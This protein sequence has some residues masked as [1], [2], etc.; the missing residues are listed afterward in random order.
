MVY[1]SCKCDPLNKVCDKMRK[2][3]VKEKQTLKE[4]YEGKTHNKSEKM[5]MITR[6]C[7]SKKPIDTKQK[8]I[9][10]HKSI[11]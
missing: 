1:E 11:F 10:L 5:K 8:I 7:K 9:S 4:H 3:T 2:M 6:I